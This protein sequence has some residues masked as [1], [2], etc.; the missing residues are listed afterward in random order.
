[1]RSPQSLLFPK[2]NKLNS[3]SLSSTG[4]VLQP[5]DHLSSPPLDPLQ[6]LQILPVLGAPG[7]DKVLQMRP[8]KSKAEG[9]NPLPLPAATP[10]L[11]QPRMLV[12]WAPSAH[13]WLLPSFLSTMS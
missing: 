10:L 3:L 2:L 1:M 11:M 8:H 6:Q 5:S 4:E 13:C 9:G 7:L 12:A